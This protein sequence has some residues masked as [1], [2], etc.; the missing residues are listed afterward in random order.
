MRI[1]HV[2]RMSVD[3]KVKAV[4]LGWLRDLESA[5]KMKRKKRNTVLY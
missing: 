4:T 1:G 5:P 3:R 2:M